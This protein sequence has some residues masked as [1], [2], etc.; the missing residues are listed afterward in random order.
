MEDPSLLKASGAFPLPEDT[1]KTAGPKP[2]LANNRFI[3]SMYPM[4]LPSSLRTAEYTL[5]SGTVAVQI[6]QRGNVAAAVDSLGIY[7]SCQHRIS[8]SASGP[9]VGGALAM[10]SKRS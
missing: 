2:F 8:F 3:E 6:E 10:I 7:H 5:R 9:V 4:V 1:I